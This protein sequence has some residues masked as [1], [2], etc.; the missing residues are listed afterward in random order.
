MYFFGLT[1][2][3]LLIYVLQ[4]A[5]LSDMQT[6]AMAV[7]GLFVNIAGW[8]HGHNQAKEAHEKEKL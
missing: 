2:A 4:T 7:G 1:G 3:G 5:P 6:V 8:L